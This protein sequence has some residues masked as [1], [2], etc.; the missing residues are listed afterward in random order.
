M[1]REREGEREKLEL[2]L[3]KETRKHPNEGEREL[4]VK[5]TPEAK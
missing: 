1:F 2:E 5:G 3:A 4:G